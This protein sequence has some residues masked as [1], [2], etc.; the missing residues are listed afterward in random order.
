MKFVQLCPLQVPHVAE[1]SSPCFLHEH[2]WEPQ[3]DL[4]LQLTISNKDACAVARSVLMSSSLP[5]TSFEP[6]SCG[7]S[8]TPL[9]SCTWW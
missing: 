7:G 2:V 8:E 3:S 4:Q 6:Q 9:H 1:Q 5:F